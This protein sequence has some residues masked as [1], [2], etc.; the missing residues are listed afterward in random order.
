MYIYIYIYREREILKY[1]MQGL[2][3]RLLRVARRGHEGGHGDAPEG[4]VCVY[5]CIHMYTHICL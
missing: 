5:I 3:L 2:R 1:C 4:G